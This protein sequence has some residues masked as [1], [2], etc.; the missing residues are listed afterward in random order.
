MTP[1]DI[2]PRSASADAPSLQPAGAIGIGDP[3][4]VTADESK[5]AGTLKA[6]TGRPS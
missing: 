3:S 6:A 1:P 5:R 4:K 2:S